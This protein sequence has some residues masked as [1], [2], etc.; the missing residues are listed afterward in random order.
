MKGLRAEL[1]LLGAVF[2]D[3]L[4]FGMIVADI[5]LRAQ[6]LVPPGLPVGLL[7]GLL[8][9]S[10]FVTQ[11]LVSPHWG[12][13]SDRWGRKPV[14]VLCTLLSAS[15]M[16][17]YGAAGSLW[18]LFASRVVS[19]FGAANVAVAQALVADSADGPART[20]A[21]GRVGGVISAGLVVGPPLG[22]F[23]AK[24]AGS[25]VVGYV[26][27]AA[28][29]V[30]ALAMWAFLP[31]PPPRE[32]AETGRRPIFDFRLLRDLPAIRPL[33]LIAVVA[34]FSLATLEGT[35]AR[36]IAR[37]FG[38]GQLQFGFIL[39]YESLL[40]VVVQSLFLG[41]LVRRWKDGRLLRA[42]Y[43]LQG[44]GLALN[45]AAAWLGVPPLATL[46][47]ASTLYAFGSGV[48]NPV[49]NG[50][51]SKLTPPDR[52]GELFGLLQ[53]ARST[54][55]VVGPMIGGVLFDLWP[56]LPYCLAGLVCAG[57]AGLV[58]TGSRSKR[59]GF[60]VDEDVE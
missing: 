42:A 37:L 31:S 5:Q 46:F 57:A 12:A 47:V 51:C 29:L 52:Q 4:G 11:T 9:A 27:G 54:G 6:A 50:L 30:G 25:H 59:I 35:F 38:Y 49:V 34:W 40:G 13:L 17:L 58:E 26:A 41:W 21:L 60:G 1:P 15:A 48:A 24:A 14:V 43:L 44:V 18:L 39:G 55:F 20:A 8:L 19:G 45:P 22:G 23:L 28:S 33:V 3:L 53:G 7:I 16:L 10:T 56:P 2:L 32:P 36:L